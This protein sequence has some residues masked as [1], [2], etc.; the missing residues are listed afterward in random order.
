MTLQHWQHG[1]SK[2]KHMLQSHQVNSSCPETFGGIVVQCTSWQVLTAA[3][4]CS[5][6]LLLQLPSHFSPQQFKEQC[7][8]AH[9]GSLPPC[10]WATRRALSTCRTRTGMLWTWTRAT[11]KSSWQFQQSLEKQHSWS[12]RPLKTRCL[13][14]MG[15]LPAW[16]SIWATWRF[17][18][19]PVQRLKDWG[20][21]SQQR[22]MQFAL[23]QRRKF[24]SWSWFQELETFG[25]AL[26]GVHLPAVNWAFWQLLPTSVSPCS[27]QT[28]SLAFHCRRVR[29]HL[30]MM[31]DKPLGPSILVCM[32]RRDGLASC[33]AERQS[34]AW[35]PSK[36]RMDVSSLITIQICMSRAVQRT[37]KIFRSQEA[38]L[39]RSQVMLT[40]QSS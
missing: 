23:R 36:Q 10:S 27:W 16:P 40:M 34:T 35:N 11:A 3:S 8:L 15:K 20:H 6:L 39:S 18:A 9:V 5:R 7:M 29:S 14:K 24:L 37:C 22:P 19:W 38:G 4:V 32:T 2:V 1:L 30:K 25:D 31:P 26:H 13:W 12:W 21:R 28:L 33:N 17:H